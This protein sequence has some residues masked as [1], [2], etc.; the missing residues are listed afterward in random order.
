MG[1]RERGSGEVEVEREPTGRGWRP[2]LGGGHQRAGLGGD[3]GSLLAEADAD[4]LRHAGFLH[5]DAVESLGGFHGAL[6]VGDDD[7]LSFERHFLNQAG[8]ADGVGL[9]E[10]RIDF[11]EDAEGAGLVFKD[12]HQEGHGRE[13]FFSAGEQEHVL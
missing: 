9:V 3:G 10:G 2:G 13:R 1:T 7:E 11:V 6:V 8:E 4:E 12:G 5:G